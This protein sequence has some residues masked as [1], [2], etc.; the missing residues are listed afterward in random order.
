M[1][2]NN[3][4]LVFNPST[5]VNELQLQLESAIQYGFPVLFENAQ[6]TFETVINQV[7]QK[8]LIKQGTSTK[9]KFGD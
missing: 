9:I 7:L 8:N 1:E 5:S 4:L 2:S 3:K 6:E